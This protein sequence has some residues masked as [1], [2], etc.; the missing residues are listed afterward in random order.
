ADRFRDRSTRPAR[1]KPAPPFSRFRSGRRADPI[2]QTGD[3]NGLRAMLAA[4][5]GA[6]LLE[7]VPNDAD[8]AVF[9]GR[10]QRM[11]RAFDMGGTVHAPPEMPC[12][13][14]FHRFHIWP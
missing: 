14:R 1:A 6:V 5:E 10:R 2:A 8:A 3:A 7:T 11:D 12:R 9:A 13:S 4:E